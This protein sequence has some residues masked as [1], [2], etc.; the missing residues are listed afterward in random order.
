[1][2]RLFTKV[3]CVKMYRMISGMEQNMTAMEIN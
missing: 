1:M 3:F 2:T